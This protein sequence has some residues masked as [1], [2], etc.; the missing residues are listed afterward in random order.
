MADK[1]KVTWLI[2]GLGLGGA[3]HLLALAARHVDRTRFEYE[4][5]FL[6]PWKRALVPDL[7]DQGIPTTCLH[8]TRPLDP[9]VIGQ[10]ARHLRGRKTDILHAHLPYTGIVGR[11]AARWAGVPGVIYT[12]HNLQERYQWMTRVAN[13]VTMR[14][15]DVTIAVSDE[16]RNSLLRSP[17]AR[18]ARVQTIL[19]GVDVDSL[20]EAAGSGHGVREEFGIAPGR[21]VVGV[22]NVFRPQKRLDLWIDAARLIARAEPETTFMVV[23]DGPMAGE[24][25]AQAERAGL[26]GRI[27]FPGLRRDAP[28]LMAAFDVFMLSSVYEGLPVAVLEAMALG[29][30]VVAT[31]V[32]GLPSVIEDGLHG[33]LVD[34]GDPAALAGRVVELLRSPDR[35][36]QLGEAAA[37]RIEAEFSI[38]QMVR[39]T[40]SLYTDVLARKQPVRPQPLESR[41]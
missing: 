11:I 41:A 3:E 34:A 8:R 5:V 12:E 21:L 36:R 16:V 9:R 23:G 35:R 24:I 30:P 14:L 25:R 32:G 10:I 28:R 26:D 1:I 19:N 27:L 40:E 17:L 38:Q 39:A 13:Q 2:K 22:V 18:R 37:Q 29:R 6:L 20:S 7:E 4:V 33:L 15:C 31:R